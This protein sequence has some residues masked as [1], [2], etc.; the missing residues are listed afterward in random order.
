[1]TP[2]RF[3]PIAQPQLLDLG[4]SARPRCS[5]GFTLAISARHA[6]DD[7][8]Q[9]WFVHPLRRLRGGE[10]LDDALLLFRPLFAL[11]PDFERKD[12]NGTDDD[13]PILQPLFIRERADGTLSN[14]ADD[15]GLLE[16]FARSRVLRRL[17]VLGPTLRN[18]PAAGLA[19]GD[20]HELRPRAAAQPVR[21]GAVLKAS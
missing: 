10:P 20:E 12:A 9:V 17:T 14:R 11:A 6:A 3:P 8:A 13:R 1:L 18:N 2:R 7:L 21:Q 16:S 15:A 19:G 5:T 4:S